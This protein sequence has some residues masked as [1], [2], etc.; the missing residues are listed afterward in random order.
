MF[1]FPCEPLEPQRNGEKEVDRSEK[2]TNR[3]RKSLNGT[4][5]ASQLKIM[6]IIT[7][8]VKDD[9]SEDSNCARSNLYVCTQ[10]STHAN[11]CQTN[12]ANLYLT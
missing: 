8:S 5:Q 7:M 9:G 11:H 10:A 12:V 6:N 1:Y 4:S 3:T 2:S